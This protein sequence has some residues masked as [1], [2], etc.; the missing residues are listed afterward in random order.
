MQE[1]VVAL[2]GAHGAGKDTVADMLPACKLAFADT[3]YTE[4]SRSFRV[5]VRDLKRRETKNVA[6][7]RLAVNASSNTA[8]VCFC[9]TNY[10]QGSASTWANVP[11]SPRKIL[12]WWANFRRAKDPD[13]FVNKTS[14]LARINLALKRRVVITDLRFDN[15]FALIQSLGGHVWQVVRPGVVAGGTGHESDHDGTR[16][17]PVRVINNNGT[18]E[19]LRKCLKQPA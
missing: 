15:E 19:D 7:K 8:F 5:E 9:L 14:L 12:Q 10:G 17:A 3:L 13:Y 4:V 18:L 11:R 2:C 1:I 6:Q 16:F